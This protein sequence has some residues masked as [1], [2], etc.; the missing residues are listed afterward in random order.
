MFTVPALPF[1]YRFFSGNLHTMS[2]VVDDFVKSPSVELL[3]KC[4]RDQLLLIAG[5]FQITVTETLKDAVK[6]TVLGNL[7]DK[8]I[9]KR[10]EVQEE[11]GENV[12]DDDEGDEDVLVDSSLGFQQKKELLMLKQ[13]HLVEV[14][15]IQQQ[16]E[17][18]KLDIEYKK[19]ELIQ[20]GHLSS[21]ALV[22]VN[23]ERGGGLKSFDIGTNMRLLPRFNEKDPDTF[24]LL[25]ERIA[26][27]RNW[28]DVDRTLMLQS[29][30]TGKAQE[31]FAALNPADSMSY[32]KVKAA[33]LK[34]Y[35][36][37]PE[38]YRQRFRNWRKQ[39]K[40]SH[41]E[42]VRDLSTQFSRWCSSSEVHN[43]EQLFNLV[44]LEQFKN[45]VPVNVATYITENKVK[46]PAEAAVLADEYVLLHR[47]SYS[48]T[49]KRFSRATGG[50]ESQGHKA[51]QV[52]TPGMSE[53]LAN[54]CNYCKGNG[55]W[56][57]ECPVRRSKENVSS[58]QVRPAAL[59]NSLRPVA[60]PRQSSLLGPSVAG[61]LPFISE[62]FLAV[63]GSGKRVPVKV[64]RDCGTLDSFVRASVLPFSSKT[65]TGETILMQ[66]M[67]MAVCPVPV[68]E[69]SLVSDLVSGE[70]QMG[71]R[72]EL[73]VEGVDVILG[74]DLCGERVW[75][76]QKPNVLTRKW[77]GSAQK[78]GLSN[79][80]NKQGNAKRKVTKPGY[81]RQTV[82]NGRTVNA[83]L[84]TARLARASSTTVATDLNR[85]QYLTSGQNSYLRMKP[86]LGNVPCQKAL[87]T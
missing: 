19:L 84:C 41:V 48:S 74:N 53:N 56:K 23:A 36:L 40:Q 3:N 51:D 78:R 61:Y 21:D 80:Q 11:L 66:G 87:K 27:A 39:D 38:A 55:H 68:H 81:S 73:P 6:A 63:K 12:H 31:A 65:H 54:L 26:D 52:G 28:P 77:P 72:P 13:Q 71:V 14:A 42:F 76:D 34:I 35:E 82:G 2:S 57:N 58:S 45:T 79:W 20:K 15:K 8:G 24:F 60:S 43:F 47:N 85:S 22:S 49:E 44:I 83:S 64:L 5:R 62:G 17:M 32:A 46:T 29:V 9:L 37:V 7:V 33:V 1:L 67:G 30:L 4:T 16:T 70:V 75:A 86:Q 69:M 10:E 50:S 25:F 59:A 18:A